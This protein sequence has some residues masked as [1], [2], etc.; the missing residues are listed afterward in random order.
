MSLVELGRYTMLY[1]AELDRARLESAG[2]FAVCFDGSMSLAEGA[3]FAI[4]VR[5]MVL[6]DQLDEARALLGASP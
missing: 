2:L 1:N 6:A 3:A 4:P 5:L